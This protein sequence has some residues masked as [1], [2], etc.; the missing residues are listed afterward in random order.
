STCSIT[1]AV[2]GK[3]SRRARLVVWPAVRRALLSGRRLKRCGRTARSS[4][5]RAADRRTPRA[6]DGGKSIRVPGVSA[7]AG[8]YRR[9]AQPHFEHSRPGRDAG[10]SG[11]AHPRAR[12]KNDEVE[13]KWRGGQ[14]RSRERVCPSAAAL[15]R[16]KAA[17]SIRLTTITAI[18]V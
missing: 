14:G 7:A 1:L 5:G 8:P 3:R 16:S 18:S 11:P 17:V 2:L 6:G 13:S 10:R 12:R 4:R 9:P 15:T